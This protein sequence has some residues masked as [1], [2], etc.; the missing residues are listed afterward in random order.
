VSGIVRFLWI[1]AIFW[2]VDLAGHT[3]E[4]ALVKQLASLVHTT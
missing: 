1:A 4:A 2:T 3:V